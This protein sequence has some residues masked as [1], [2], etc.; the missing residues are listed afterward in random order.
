[1]SGAVSAE[2]ARR[3]PDHPS[4]VPAALLGPS[5][6]REAWP[7]RRSGRDWTVDIVCVI[8]SAAVGAWLLIL[9]ANGPLSPSSALL[10]IDGVLG[11]ISCVALWFR[12]RLPVGVAVLTAVLSVV[13]VSTAMAA[14]VAM[15]TVAVHRRMGTAVAIGLLNIGTAALFFALYPQQIEVN[16]E[17]VPLWIPIVTTAAILAAIVAWG[18]L[19]RARRQLVMSLH[20]RAERAEAE[21]RLLA[22]Q[23]RLAE[24]TRIAREMHDVLAH[25]VSLMALH[26]GALQ[27]RPDLPPDEVER[28][29]GLIRTT[30]RQALEELRGVIG[31]LRDD[32]SPEAPPQTPQPTLADIARLV[33]DSRRAG[34]SIEYRMDVEGA[35]RAPGVLGR[36][37]FRIVQEALTNVNK[38]APGT[39]TRVTVT[40]GPGAGLHV[41]VRNKLPLPTPASTALPGAGTGLVG[42]AER[43]GLSGGSL[44]HGP[45]DD[46]D[47]VVRADL[48]WPE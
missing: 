48:R 45:T 35:D 34:A 19:V 46:G 32:G 11:L 29:A 10:V 14:T 33:D 22:E 37:A 4:L 6:D 15:F 44:H 2:R 20:E 26:A 1:M 28:T 36:D 8:L 40:G 16:G 42:L 13:S 27:I 3:G 41:I 24:R 17:D 23:A 31:V 9:T 38:H 43:A 18:M 12:R 39:A 30:A 47:F 21:Q 25:R 5:G 7:I